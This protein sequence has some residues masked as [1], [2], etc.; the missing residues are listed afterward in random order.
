MNQNDTNRHRCVNNQL[1]EQ[2]CTVL[3]REPPKKW[4][5]QSYHIRPIPFPPKQ[6]FRP[7]LTTEEQ[8]LL[9]RVLGVD[10]V[11]DTA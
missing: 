10:H 1:C 4:H 8:D 6:V 7:A 11:R 5:V 9:I 3:H 2:L